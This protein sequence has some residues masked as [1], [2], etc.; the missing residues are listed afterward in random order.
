MAVGAFAPTAL[1]LLA[2]R[3]SWQGPLR[4]ILAMMGQRSKGPL[5]F[6]PIPVVNLAEK[7]LVC[8]AQ[9]PGLQPLSLSSSG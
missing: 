9:G 7:A 8:Q 1:A 4:Q 6:C 2:T 5:G 3:G